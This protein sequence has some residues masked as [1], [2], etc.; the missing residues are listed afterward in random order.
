MSETPQKNYLKNSM[1]VSLVVLGSLLVFSIVPEITIGSFTCKKLDILADVKASKENAEAARNKKKDTI[2][3]PVTK[4][5]E[6]P[7]G[8]QCIEGD[9]KKSGMFD[10]FRKLK[11]SK[12]S[13][14]RIAWFGD[15]Y[16]EGDM[17]VAHLRDTLQRIFGG[18][19][20]GYV[21]ITSPA[22]GARATIL[23]TYKGWSRKSIVEKNG[24][25]AGISGDAWT[26]LENAFASFSVSKMLNWNSLSGFNQ[27]GILYKNNGGSIQL[28]STE[29][30]ELNISESNEI[31][32]EVV[33]LKNA[34]TAKV[35]AAGNVSLY[36]LY[37]ND[38]T[39][40]YIDNYALRG[41]SGVGNLAIPVATY[42]RCQELLEY[43]LIVL[44]YGLNAT[45][46][47]S[48]NNDWY[49]EQFDK[50]VK[51][52]KKSFPNVPILIIGVP[53]RGQRKGG[54]VKTMTGIVEM[55]EMQKNVAL[56][57]QCLYWNLFEA[58]GGENAVVKMVKN[59]LAAKDYTHVTFKGGQHIAGL[60]ASS[61]LHL[62]YKNK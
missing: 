33:D 20:V 47:K 10:F 12:K 32:Y 48:K 4:A 16:S 34:K 43:D 61:F 19:G 9:P 5:A 49:A 55:V 29:N 38:E 7:T 56:R 15:S 3:S 40:L 58:M 13:R 51:H 50:M 17:I 59:N 30:I 8:I 22:A 18:R 6:C 23:H 54:V 44:Q 60:F 24:H 36:G 35:S 2:N 26:P 28:K 39:G 37:L 25:L 21:P 1:R 31:E 42:N 11:K 52:M 14:V 27:L 45:G 53:D 46:G 62:Y 57:N 41:N